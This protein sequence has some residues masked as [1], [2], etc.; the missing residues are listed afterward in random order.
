MRKCN[1]H[2]QE[3]NGFFCK[4]ERG[5]E[6]WILHTRNL[7]M[8]SPKWHSIR[9]MIFIGFMALI[10]AFLFGI[11]WMFF[12]AG[13][14]EMEG[15]CNTGFIGV[16]FQGEFENEPYAIEK[17]KGFMDYNFTEHDSEFLGKYLNVRNIDGMNCHFKMK[18]NAIALGGFQ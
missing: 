1:R 5:C 17:Q 18:G 11:I 6:A 12:N 15:N 10:I 7:Q 16:D 9:Q 2:K 3:C 8:K 14:F 13:N 4:L